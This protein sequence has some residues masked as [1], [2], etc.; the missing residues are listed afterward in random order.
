MNLA[1]Q[2]PQPDD[3]RS[4]GWLLMT[5]AALAVAGHHLLKVL[6]HLRGKPPQP[7]NQVLDA[8]QRALE[9]RVVMMEAALTGLR[10]EVLA[11]D[12]R[13]EQAARA[14]SAGLHAALHKVREDLSAKWDGERAELLQRI[15][16][17][18][19]G[20]SQYARDTERALGRIEGKLEGSAVCA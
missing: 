19:A 3:Y 1:E 16:A 11:G 18:N 15:D 6:K 4:V 5:L 9:Q 17:V 12:E 14:R 8:S 10:A 20:V 2:L 13:A 7:P